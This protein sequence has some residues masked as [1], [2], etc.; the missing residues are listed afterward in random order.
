MLLERRVIAVMRYARDLLVRV[1]IGVSV[2]R[3]KQYAFAQV[4]HN[5][6]YAGDGDDDKRCRKDQRRAERV[7]GGL[8]P[9]AKTLRAPKYSAVAAVAKMYAAETRMPP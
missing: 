1:G 6:Q 5:H 2:G 4:H 8:Q 9:N 3:A 7:V